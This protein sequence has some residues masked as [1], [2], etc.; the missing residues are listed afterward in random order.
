MRSTSLRG[1]ATL[2][3]VAL[4]LGCFAVNPAEAG[5]KK[6][7]RKAKRGRN[8]ASAPVVPGSGNCKAAAPQEED[9]AAGLAAYL[10]GDWKAAVDALSAWSAKDGA[11]DAA[12]AGRGIYSL[13][14]ALQSLRRTNEANERYTQAR[15]LLEKSSAEA[16]TLESRYYLTSLYRNQNEPGLQLDLVSLTL[17]DLESG[18]LCPAPDA[19]DDFRHSRLLSFAGREE[20]KAE[21]LRRAFTK[22]ESG[23]GKL[24]AYHSL[25]AK[26][27][28]DL[29]RRSHAELLKQNG[30]P[31]QL[32]A[33]ATDWENAA[34][35]SAELEPKTPGVHWSVGMAMLAQD[36]HGDAAAYWRKNWRKERQN[37]NGMVY[38]V[39]VLADVASYRELFGEAE[40][41]DKLRTFTRAGLEQNSLFEA[42]KFLGIQR[43]L[44]VESD[45][46]DD[47]RTAKEL[48]MKLFDYRMNQFLGEYV[49]RGY[50]LQE[51]ALQNQLLPAIHHRALPTR[52]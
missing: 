1:L 16:P 25:A 11:T 50:D 44:G 14:F 36:R 39:R 19:D 4:V 32:L 13:A 49:S 38:A 40:R 24:K 41:V 12:G 29:S 17:T 30:D 10:E 9:L 20:Q 5:R 3:A 2:L 52:S 47:Q 21:V 18:E 37:G 26:E 42:K 22:Y 48:E 45:M 23:G 31:E 33:L 6:K 43:E 34:T 27:L 28:G 51:F 15:P 35:R 7:K 8:N 46:D